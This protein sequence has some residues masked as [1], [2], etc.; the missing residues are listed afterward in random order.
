MKTKITEWIESLK[1]ADVGEQIERDKEREERLITKSKRIRCECHHPKFSGGR[2]H[3]HT[4]RHTIATHLGFGED[5][6][7]PEN[8]IIAENEDYQM[9]IIK[10]RAFDVR[11]H[12][13]RRLRVSDLS[14]IDY[15]PQGDVWTFAHCSKCLNDMA[16]GKFR[17][18]INR[19][20]FR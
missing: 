16:V 17:N 11:C 12:C 9:A 10:L 18:H 2:C 4:C 6:S 13:G 8:M 5:T 19:G 14:Q 1:A 15:R 7:D 20:E 3:Y